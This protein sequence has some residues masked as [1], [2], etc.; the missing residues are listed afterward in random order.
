[1]VGLTGVPVQFAI[2]GVL[3]SL[4]M[5][6]IAATVL[7]VESAVL[8]NFFW[9]ERWTWP[10]GAGTKSGSTMSRLGAFNLT[11]GVISILENVGFMTVLVEALDIPYLV[12]NG[13]SILACSLINFVVSDRF[14]FRRVEAW[15]VPGRYE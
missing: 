13:I 1:M 14:V 5:H 8:N 3:T 2:L 15:P 12:A 9:H 4:G 6:Y 11:V 10:D 7:A